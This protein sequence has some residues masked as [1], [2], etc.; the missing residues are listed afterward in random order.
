MN[1]LTGLRA[2]AGEE[3]CS[4]GSRA[5]HQG[6][7]RPVRRLRDRRRGDREPSRGRAATRSSSTAAARTARPSTWGCAGSSCPRCAPD[8]R[9]AEPL[10]PVG[11]AP[12]RP[13]HRRCPVFNAANAPLLPLLRA[14]RI[15][16]A[17]HVDG[18][19]WKRGKW[20]P[21]GRRYDL[22]AERAAVRWADVLIADALGIQAYY[23]QRYGAASR[24]LPMAHRSDRPARAPAPRAGAQTTGL[25]P[26][27]ARLEPEN[28]VDVVLR[29]YLASSCSS[30]SWSSGRAAHITEVERLAGADRRVRMSAAS[31]TR[32][33]STPC[34]AEPRATC[35]GTPSA[36]RTSLLR[37][38]GAGA[39]VSPST[40]TSTA[41]VAGDA[42]LYF[43]DDADVTSALNRRRPNRPRRRSGQRP[44]AVRSRSATAGTRSRPATRTSAVTWREGAPSVQTRSRIR[45]RRDTRVS[46]PNNSKSRISA[47]TV[48]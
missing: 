21:T 35:T 10:G 5:G 33:C 41:E 40:S 1:S 37:A 24:F 38:L 42:G 26:R 2:P 29:G 34:Y 36:G 9:D 25:P 8:G 32:N 23:R 3:G 22:R 39:G 14:A 47:L 20:G 4:C 31:G 19:E 7:P 44:G 12:A 46:F 18:L 28:H 6:G 43:A 13:P 45:D 11:R 27:L 30:R 17:V 48:R 15:P 16:A